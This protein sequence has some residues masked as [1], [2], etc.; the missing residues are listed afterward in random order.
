MAINNP[1]GLFLVPGLFVLLH[2]TAL[3]LALVYYRRCPAACGLVILA[4]TLGLV[5]TIGRVSFQL[6]LIHGDGN[7]QMFSLAMLGFNIGSWFA[8]GLLIVAVFAGRNQP[9]AQRSRLDPLDDDD[10]WDRPAVATKLPGATGIQ[11]RKP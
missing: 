1:M 3:I 5:V 7:P 4:S 2:L 11:E 6:L 9:P 8:Y 10:D